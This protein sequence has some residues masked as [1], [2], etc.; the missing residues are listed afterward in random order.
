[1]RLLRCLLV[2]ASVAPFL[3]AM[4]PPRY[5]IDN[6][7]NKNT[8]SDEDNKRITQY[9]TGWAEAL[10]TT[11]TTELFS[12]RHRLISPLEIDNDMSP[13]V[14][15]VYCR[16]VLDGVE[17]LLSVENK[18][19]MGLVNALQ[20]LSVIGNEQTS[21]VL[22][23]MADS[24]DEE[25]DSARL[26]ASIGLGKSFTVGALPFRK[27]KS[28]ATRLCSLIVNE[29]RWFV[30][31]EQIASLEALQNAK[32]LD[33]R[34]KEELGGLSLE[35][36]TN[37]IEGL[38][39]LLGKT[40]LDDER[41][42]ALGIVLPSIRFQL[43]NPDLDITSRDEAQDKLMSSLISLVEFCTGK[44]A[45]LAENESLFNSYGQSMNSAGMI[46]DRA[47][48]LND[49]TT[50]SVLELWQSDNTGAILDRVEEWK[51]NS[52]N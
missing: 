41:V 31:A 25:R 3:V 20:V 30:I 37:A 13:Y 35:L 47:L 42:L 49:D 21:R 29:P 26:W 39:R 4:A 33:S 24:M 44:S 38:V 52:K 19:E 34:D 2:C 5:R 23:S 27:I 10:Q 12:A 50:V 22:L 7:V 14:R 6:I 48:G 28:D 17:P 16:G 40:E 9:A 36:Q 8:L 18:N 43:I 32:N 15:S 11:D 45:Y 1:M 46:V 51:K